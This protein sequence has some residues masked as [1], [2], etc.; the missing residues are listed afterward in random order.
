MS[1]LNFSFTILGSF[2]ARGRSLVSIL[3]PPLR[4]PGGRNERKRRAV[5]AL[6]LKGLKTVFTSVMNLVIILKENCARLC[7]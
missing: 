5:L 4:A 7:Q 3:I 1:I 2:D 6:G